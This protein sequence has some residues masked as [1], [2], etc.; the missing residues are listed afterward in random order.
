MSESSSARPLKRAVID[1]NLFISGLIAKGL[2][3]QLIS[4]FRQGAFI[5]I[6]SPQLRSELEEVLSREKFRVRY[7]VSDEIRED[8]LSLIDTN[9]I[10]AN[11]R[12]RLPVS[13]R[14]PKDEIV[15]ATALGGRADVIV[16]GDDDLLVLNG[17]PRLGRLQIITVRAFLELLEQAE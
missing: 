3:N 16:T 11:P 13:I 6:I 14:D 17:D 10:V 8:I 2:P 9:G 15:L 4:K 7:R 12:R 1:L 5:L